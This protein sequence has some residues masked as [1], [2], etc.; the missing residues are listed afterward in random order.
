MT[1]PERL[2]TA[3]SA[4]WPSASVEAR[5]GWLLREG[6]G[7]GKRV[8]AAMAAVPGDVPDIDMAIADMEARG[9]S[10]LFHLREADA[11]LD[12][13]LAAR[14][15]QIVDRTLIYEAPAAD[16]AGLAL[17]PGL[18]WVEV[19]ARLKLLEEIWAAGGIGPARLA[20]MAR[21]AGPHAVIM[22]RTDNAVAGC[23]HV[24]ADGEIAM[25]H[26][27]EVRAERRR[28]GGGSALLAGAAHWALAQGAQTL[29]LAVT[30]ANAGA[31]ALY[32]K[33]GM[34][35]SARYRYRAAP[36]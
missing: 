19:N 35:V 27:A 34:Q 29:A 22:A 13:A 2:F 9:Q 33:A 21:C 10:P 32:E 26:A 6:A 15:F 1:A 28:E 25:I 36:V 24:A 17:K 7:G 31:R 8:S 18:R 11:A 16:L 3:L 12:G 5:D 23:A 4:T 20:V 30:E 14:R